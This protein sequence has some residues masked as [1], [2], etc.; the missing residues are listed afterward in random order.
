MFKEFNGVRRD[1]VLLYLTL[2]FTATCVLMCFRCSDRNEASH[3]RRRDVRD[4]GSLR[5]RHQ[6]I[7]EQSATHRYQQYRR[8][9]LRHHQANTNIFLRRINHHLVTI[10]CDIYVLYRFSS[11]EGLLNGWGGRY[12]RNISNKVK[13]V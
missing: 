4:N 13:L 6:V 3:S 7:S 10:F 5:S 2:Y 9:R 12:K 1:K 11:C 8:H